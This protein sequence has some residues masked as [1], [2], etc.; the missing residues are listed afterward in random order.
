MAEII[1]AILAHFLTRSSGLESVSGFYMSIDRKPTTF[2]Y[3]YFFP[4]GLFVVV[5]WVSFVIPPDSVPARVTLIITTFLV[6]VNVA[7]SVFNISP[8]APNVNPIQVRSQL[9]ML[10]TFL[11]IWILGCM[12]F[13]FASVIEYAIILSYQRYTIRKTYVTRREIKRQGMCMRPMKNDMVGITENSMKILLSKIDFGCMCTSC[14]LFVI[15]NIV[16]WATT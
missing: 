5:S 2:I 9:T 14:A 8:V 7:N 12:A 16:F 10:A 11:Q 3:N 15:F 13:V 6:L 1:F 4:T